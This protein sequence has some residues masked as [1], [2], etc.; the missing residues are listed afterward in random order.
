MEGVDHRLT[1]LAAAASTCWGDEKRRSADFFFLVL[2]SGTQIDVRVT[3]ERAAR[4]GAQPVP[5][6]LGGVADGQ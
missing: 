6:R 3:R 4:R 1:F 2:R 5:A